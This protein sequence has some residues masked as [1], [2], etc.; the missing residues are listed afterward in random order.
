M[1]DCPRLPLPGWTPVSWWYRLTHNIANTARLFWR[2]LFWVSFPLGSVLWWYL[3][4]TVVRLCSGARVRST[5]DKSS[6][7]VETDPGGVDQWEACALEWR[8]LCFFF[9]LSCGML[10]RWIFGCF[11]AVYAKENLTGVRLRQLWRMMVKEED[12]PGRKCCPLYIRA[13]DTTLL[14]MK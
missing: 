5:K 7:P 1:L 8:F 9:P 2:V 11:L 3:L 14:K 10:G 13:Q 12:L 6:N 4:V